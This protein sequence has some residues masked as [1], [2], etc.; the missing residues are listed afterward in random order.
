MTVE[1][2]VSIREP[3]PTCSTCRFFGARGGV[4]IWDD[5]Y[6]G[7]DL[8]ETD[9]HACARIIHGNGQQ[10]DYRK[11]NSEPAIVTDGSG[12]AARLR[13]LPSFGCALHEFARRDG[14][15]ELHGSDGD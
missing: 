12:Y 9:H 5:E 11:V 7:G 14:E 3:M 8:R 1:L 15:M 13:V 4:E 10:R 6:D 2:P